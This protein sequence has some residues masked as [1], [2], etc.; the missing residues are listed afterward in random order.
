MPGEVIFTN[1]THTLWAKLTVKCFH[2]FQVFGASILKCSHCFIGFRR[3]YRHRAATYVTTDDVANDNYNNFIVD[4]IN[5][6]LNSLAT[7]LVIDVC[8]PRCLFVAALIVSDCNNWCGQ[9]W[10]LKE[11]HSLLIHYYGSSCG[12]GY[13]SLI[14][15]PSL[16]LHSCILF[17]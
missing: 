11:S 13:V 4:N 5:I 10:A 9:C 1:V 15:L 6:L 3:L 2:Y 8:W 7:N 14:G 17:S 16:G 12:S